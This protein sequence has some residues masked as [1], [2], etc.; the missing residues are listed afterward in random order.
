MSDSGVGCI[1]NVLT[2]E[3]GGSCGTVAGGETRWCRSWFFG[4]RWLAVVGVSRG[5]TERNK[6]EGRWEERRNRIRNNFVSE[7]NKNACI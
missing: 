3:T 1:C 7:G 2:K 5:L 4:R 6:R